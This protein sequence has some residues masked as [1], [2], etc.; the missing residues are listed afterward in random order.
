[1]S[2]RTPREAKQEFL[3]DLIHSLRETIIEFTDT[4]KGH[5]MHK[6]FL[7]ANRRTI[8]EVATKHGLSIQPKTV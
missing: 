7:E 2:A 1:M 3:N 5:E 6:L 8:K 4:A